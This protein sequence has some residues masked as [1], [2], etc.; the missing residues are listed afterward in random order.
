MPYS[1]WIIILLFELG[2]GIKLNLIG[3][4]SVSELFLLIFVPLFVLPKVKW[5]EAVGVKQVTMAYSALLGFQILSEFMV[6]NNLSSALKGIAI[7]VVSY[8][9]FMFLIYYLARLKLL[10]L[11]LVVAQMARAVVFGTDIEEQS[12]EDVMSGEGATYL[13]FYISPIVISFSLAMSMIFK[14]KNFALLHSLLG[15][16]LI[17]LGSRSSG[18]I[19]LATGLVTY[20]FEHRVLTYN[21]K[22]IVMSLV[23]GCMI[24]YAFY[25]YYVN[26]VLYGEITSGNSRQVFLCSNPYNPLELLMAG[27]SEVWIGWQAFM[28]NFWFG[29]GAWAYD[30]TGRYQRMM[31]ALHGELS[32]FT[33]SQVSYHF[34]IPS[35]SVLIGSGMMN[36]VF[37]F[38]SMGVIVVYFL[39]K[40]VLSFIHC[41]DRYKLVLVN[42]VIS[43][44]WT[45][46]FSPQS[47]FRLTMPVAFAIIFVLSASVENIKTVEARRSMAVRYAAFRA[48]KDRILRRKMRHIGK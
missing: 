48:A 42:S 21:K 3:V 39:R 7:T 35:H 44:F 24:G 38:L 6:G 5:N 37:A 27:R 31:I 18:G 16:V 40:G 8:L 46:L 45:A 20:M 30:S 10:I 11:V 32:T 34:L 12:I 9:H 36:G 17:V 15:I 47:H 28:D 23:L 25:V 2:F 19:A 43:L 13:K 33:R 26:R 14:Y 1:K 29:H 22:F 4:I 41:D